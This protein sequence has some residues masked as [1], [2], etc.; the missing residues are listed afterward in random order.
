VIPQLTEWIHG[1]A[2][3]HY[4]YLP[5]NNIPDSVSP[6]D[7]TSI[8][9]EYA[10]MVS[11]EVIPAINRLHTFFS[12]EYLK[13]SRETSGISVLPRGKEWYQFLI[14]YH[15]TTEM[16]ADEIY[17]LG[18]TE[19]ARL[20]TEM[21]K[22]VFA[23]GFEGSLQEFFEHVRTKP[24]LMPFKD[25]SEVIANFDAI[26]QKMKPQLASL[27]DRTPKAAFEIR[28]TESFREAS[29]SAEYIPGSKD[30][31]RPGIFYVPVPDVTKYNYFADEVLFL[32]EAIPGHHYQM[33]LA[34]ENNKLPSFRKTLYYSANAEGWA[35]YCESLGRELG[36]YEDP[37][38]YFGVLSAEMHRAIRLVVDTGIHSK[39]WTREQAI[40]YSL[41]NEA[42]PEATIIFE[43]ERY[44][45]GPGQA[46]S[47][48]IGHLKIRELRQLAEKKLGENFDIRIFHNKIL[49]LG[50]VPLDLL[51]ANILKWIGD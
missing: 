1:T 2:E 44:M 25:P 5:A 14:K 30:S 16:T 35:L 23:V 12:T 3:N 51:E 26:H 13:V 38:Q 20:R 21:K 42:K 28:R 31:S 50:S 27:F 17:E 11:Q 49:D 6:D 19:V 40:Q 46:L 8:K 34:Q 39:G 15:T 37:Y 48:Q 41:E 36:L 7:A 33:S 47:Y 24:E 32:H 9:N 45:A 22:V 10:S 29:A 43:I 18:K 4:F